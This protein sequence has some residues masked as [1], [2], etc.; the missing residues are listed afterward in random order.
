MSRNEKTLQQNTKSMPLNTAG[1]LLTVRDIIMHDINGYGQNLQVI[2]G[3]LGV[4]RFDIYDPWT[5]AIEEF[6]EVIISELSC[7]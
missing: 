2:K 3:V 5:G 4:L 6:P 7:L 1:I